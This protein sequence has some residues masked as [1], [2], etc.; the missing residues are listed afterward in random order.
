MCLL[1]FVR[2]SIIILI[3][4]YCT[5]LVSQDFSFS[6]LVYLKVSNPSTQEGVV[7]HMEVVRDGQAFEEHLISDRYGES[8]AAV[9]HTRDS[10]VLDEHLVGLTMHW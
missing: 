5:H 4:W 1:Y 10:T 9:M 2:I 3:K 7:V 8:E 6:K